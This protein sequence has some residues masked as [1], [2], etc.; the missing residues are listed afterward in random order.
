[1]D[2]SN[3]ESRLL[4]HDYSYPND[5]IEQLN[6]SIDDAAG[7]ILKF[8]DIMQY[9]SVSEGRQYSTELDLKQMQL[10]KEEIERIYQRISK[11]TKNSSLSLF[12]PSKSF[13]EN[14]GGTKKAVKLLLAEGRT[15]VQ[16]LQTLIFKTCEGWPDVVVWLLTSGSRVAYAKIHAA[17]IIH[18]VIPEQRGRDCG[19]IKTVYLKPLKC[20]KHINSESSCCCIAAKIELMAWMGP[21]RQRG[22]FDS[23]LPAGHKLKNKDYAMVIKCS[24]LVV[25]CRVN[26]YR[27]KLNGSNDA[28]NVASPFVRVNFM[29][30]IKETQIQQ[31]TVNPVWNEVIRISRNAYTSPER[32]TEYPPEVLVEVYDGD[33]TDKKELI[34]RLQVEPVV[35]DRR[36][37]APQLEWQ[38]LLKGDEPTGRILISAQLMQMPEKLLKTTYYSPT[39]ES[40]YAP[41]VKEQVDVV[42]EEP[43]PLPSSLIPTPCTYKVDVYWWGLRNVSIT[44]KPCVVLEMED[45]TIKSSIITD[46]KTNCNF[47]NGKTSQIFEAN[48][49]ESNCSPLSVRLYD[50]STFG[51]TLFLGLNVVKK[52]HKYM[53]G[54]IPKNEREESLYSSSIMSAAFVQ[55]NRMVFVKRSLR[56]NTEESED[57]LSHVSSKKSF[58]PMKA[59]VS[60][61][62]RILCNKEADEEEYTLLPIFSKEKSQIKVVKP[63]PVVEKDWWMRYSASL[64]DNYDDDKNISDRIAIYDSELECQPEFSRFKDW[65]ST[66]KIYNGKKTG[67]PEKD[68]QLHCG[69]LK[70]GIAIYKWPPPG[71]TVAVSPC[72]VE[73]DRGYF[74]DYPENE[75]S[76]YLVRVYVV[77]A[78]LLAKDLTEKS[79]PYVTVQCGRKLL[80]DRNSHATKTVNPVFGK[81]YELRASLPEDYL[82][83]VSLLNCDTCEPDDLIGTTCIDLEDRVYTKHRASVGLATEYN[84]V[85]ALRWRDYQK[86]S[87]IL[88]DLCLKNHLP[89]PMFPDASSVMVNGVEYK[90]CDNGK[91]YGST[92]ERKENICLNLLHKWHTLPICGHRLVPEHV[93]TRTLFHPEK[94]DVEQGKIQLWVDMFPLESGLF[95]PAPVDI[96]PRHVEEFEL[97]VIVWDVRDVKLR[98][99]RADIYVK[100]WIGPSDEAQDTDIHFESMGGEGSFNWR[101]IFHFHYQHAERK[102][103]LQEKGPFTEVEEH[104]PPILI[105]QV[106]DSAASPDEFLGTLMLDLTSMPRG[107]KIARHCTPAILER[108][109]INLFVVRTVRAWW[110]LKTLDRSTGNYHPDGMIDLELTLLPKEK[111]VLMPVG[112]GREAPTPL[113]DPKRPKPAAQ[114]KT[115]PEGIKIKVHAQCKTIL[116][117]IKRHKRALMSFGLSILLLS[118]IIMA[119]AYW[120]LPSMMFDTIVEPVKWEDSYVLRN[121]YP[122]P[123]P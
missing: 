35:D 106:Q 59:K 30:T 86:P 79:H 37:F 64:A 4:S 81:M 38:D 15:V 101:M 1:M 26:I 113:P 89:P 65:C 108:R 52:P 107:A 62:R 31:K 92:A 34:G 53:V 49:G 18:S 116:D 119:C 47:P 78:N 9:S 17:D 99:D 76:K 110:P 95:I 123:R 42:S 88:E 105:V 90:D 51:R 66:L 70:V 85:G 23:C 122:E 21:Y 32:L 83:K 97:R 55:V 84:L 2:L 27:A 117:C 74:D 33:T 48:L 56:S 100:A 60:I 54:W 5:L 13:C 58:Q 94:P 121:R 118:L 98:D 45:V 96:T 39:Q 93:E 41:G 46:A 40:F 80:G 28:P 36:D 16:D 102:L 61:W 67:I 29:N 73:L 6:R 57:A 8:L 12:P 11:K 19:E 10:Q 71:N 111:A 63:A 14:E 3:A 20:P 69:Y 103:V 22:A 112:V 75:P 87:I 120:D 109:K 44:H 114:K 25:E 24:P 50:S 115:D 43:E 104:F 82:L 72:G 77:K 91:K 7:K 68:E